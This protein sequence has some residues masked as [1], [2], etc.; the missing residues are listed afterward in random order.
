MAL[1]AGC[2]RC[3]GTSSWR[4]QAFRRQAFVPVRIEAEPGEPGNVA[5]AP[6]RPQMVSRRAK[7]GGIEIEVTRPLPF[8]ALPRP[9]LTDL[10]KDLLRKRDDEE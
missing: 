3:G 5:P 7:L 10:A 6:T 9:A 8:T 2:S 4:Q 1:S